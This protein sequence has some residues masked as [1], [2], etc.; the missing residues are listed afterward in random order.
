MNVKPEQIIALPYYPALKLTLLYKIREN[1]PLLEYLGR[2]SSA[3][4]NRENKK[5]LKLLNRG[6]KPIVYPK[7]RICPDYKNFYNDDEKK[8]RLFSQPFEYFNNPEN[9]K[10]IKKIFNNIG[11]FSFFV[12]EINSETQSK[13]KFEGEDFFFAYN[14]LKKIRKINK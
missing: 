4:T 7:I 10:E 14:Y 1:C 3:L 6:L 12:V 5:E 8:K 13:L 2:F 11:S 9:E